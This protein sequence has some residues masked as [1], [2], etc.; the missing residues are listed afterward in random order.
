MYAQQLILFLESNFL[1]SFALKLEQQ[2][3]RCFIGKTVYLLE[4][5]FGTEAVS[6]KSFSQLTTVEPL[7]SKLVVRLVAKNNAYGVEK[8]N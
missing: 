8:Q 4:Y 3:L 6:C 1:W 7:M 2:A 5:S